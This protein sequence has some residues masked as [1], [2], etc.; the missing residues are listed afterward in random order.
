[1]ENKFIPSIETEIRKLKSLFISFMIVCLLMGAIA[2]IR[3]E[4]FA[5][6]LF[7]SGYIFLIALSLFCLWVIYTVIRAT[8]SRTRRRMMIK[9]GKRV[10]G[11]V[12]KVVWQRSYRGIKKGVRWVIEYQNPQRKEW[13]SP[14]YPSNLSSVLE[15]E[16]GCVLYVRGRS[17][18]LAEDQPEELV[19]GRWRKY[20]EEHEKEIVKAR[21]DKMKWLTGLPQIKEGSVPTIKYSI[22]SFPGLSADERKEMDKEWRSTD[23]IISDSFFR[24]LPFP[25]FNRQE[26][27]FWVY[28]EIRYENGRPDEGTLLLAE[29]KLYQKLNDVAVIHDLKG[30]KPTAYMQIIQTQMQQVIRELMAKHTPDLVITDVFVEPILN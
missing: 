7:F 2:L 3:D 8:I 11:V 16:C 18:C 24:F 27:L 20:M 15:P 29:E 6:A 9:K 10:E 19:R 14:L 28:V 1:M 26:I 30:E 25:F 4:S 23:Y 22:E 5:R 21:Y 17:V 13:K 12:R